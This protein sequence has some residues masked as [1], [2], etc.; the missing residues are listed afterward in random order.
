MDG[1]ILQNRIL[2]FL[3]S[4]YSNDHVRACNI[5]FC[6]EVGIYIVMHGVT[7]YKVHFTDIKTGF[8]L[9]TKRDKLLF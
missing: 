6:Y 5:K 3:I 1:N 7:S 2:N 9:R 4:N 8:F